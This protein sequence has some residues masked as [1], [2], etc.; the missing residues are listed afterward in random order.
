[1]ALYEMEPR[2]AMSPLRRQ[3]RRRIGG[4]IVANDRFPIG[5]ALIEQAINSRVY[6][7]G[8]VARRDQDANA[9][10]RVPNIVAFSL[11]DSAVEVLVEPS[12]NVHGR[13]RIYHGQGDSD[14]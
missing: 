1:M 3:G 8:S 9:R 11:R 13:R 2:I 12:R 4:A 6:S 10:H 5:K 7:L 14:L